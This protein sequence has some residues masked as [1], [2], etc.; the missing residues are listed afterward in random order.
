MTEIATAAA[1]LNE[2]TERIGKLLKQNGAALAEAADAVEKTARADGL[3]YIFGTGH[4]H[5]MAEEAHY[6]AGGLALTVPILSGPTMVHEG[7]VAGTVFER[8]PGLVAPIFDR[9]PIG[10]DDVLI[11]VS[12]SGVNAA[13]VEA[14]QIGKERGATVIAI[15]SETYS[16]AAAKGRTRLADVADIVLDNGAPPGDAITAVPGSALRVGPISTPVGAAMM[17][18]VLAEVAARLQASGVQAP[19]YLSANMPGAAEVNE[20]LIARYRP[21]NPHL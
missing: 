18:A 16:R 9:Y 14:A 1:Y 12:N 11:I 21:R 5:T 8:M 6:R 7:A 15:T 13:P 3:V 4:S 20:A 19:I 10:P 17:N 2:L